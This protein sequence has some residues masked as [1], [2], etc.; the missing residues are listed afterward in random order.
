M[1]MKTIS[2]EEAKRLMAE[3][4]RVVDVREPDEHARERIEG[5]KN[6]PLSRLEQ[7]S[8]DLD[9]VVL[10]H[11]KSGMRTRNAADRLAQMSGAC[12]AYIVEGGLDALRKAGAPVQRDASQP[13][14]LQRQ[15]QIAAGALG[16]GGTI[17]GLGLSPW[18]F[19]VP[20]FVGAGLIFAG[21]TGFCGMARLLLRAP[22]NARADDAAR[23]GASA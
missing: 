18:F 9:G 21:V 20:A 13:L 11:C 1:T 14:E 19:A 16:L 5:A 23:S 10:F 6:A 15:V 12:E 17:L 2:A 8:L 7:T 4:A 3:G 22:W